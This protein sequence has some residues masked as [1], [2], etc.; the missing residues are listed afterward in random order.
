MPGTLVLLIGSGLCLHTK[1]KEMILVEMQD[2]FTKKKK[3]QK[4]TMALGGLVLVRNSG[5]QLG[6]SLS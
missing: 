3:I 4:V 2:F 1:Y 5:L 6:C